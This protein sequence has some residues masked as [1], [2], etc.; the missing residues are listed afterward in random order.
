VYRQI[1]VWYNSNR[2]RDVCFV[3]FL[4]V[5][6]PLDVFLSR[7]QQASSGIR[8]RGDGAGAFLAAAM[9]VLALVV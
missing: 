6:P 8:A 1:G 5:I 2:R 7:Y 3:Y 9:V 4:N